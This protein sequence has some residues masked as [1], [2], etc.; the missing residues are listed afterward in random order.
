MLRWEVW[1]FGLR[2]KVTARR[3]VEC[4]SETSW[5]NS[6]ALVCRTVKD[7]FV[8]RGKR[9]R[10]VAYGI[11]GIT[12]HLLLRGYYYFGAVGTEYT[13]FD[14]GMSVVR[15]TD[16]ACTPS[17]SSNGKW[18]GKTL[19]WARINESATSYQN[20]S[21]IL[22]TVTVR[23]RLDAECR[24]LMTLSMLSLSLLSY[25]CIKHL[26]FLIM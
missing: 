11:I 3:R 4:W 1:D 2:M 14:M 6:D 5:K 9:K 20:S 15:N 24:Y 7:A 18:Q 21:L 25:L 13:V 12:Q 23:K 16:I 26:Y 19:V 22:L 8:H 17:N 10:N